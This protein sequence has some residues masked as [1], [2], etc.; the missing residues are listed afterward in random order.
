MPAAAPAFPPLPPRHRF[1]GERTAERILDA[2]EQLFAE[3]GYNGTTLRDVATRVGVRPPSLYNHFASKDAL[4]AAVLERG[5][6]PLM[7][8]LARS[9]AA[10]A[11]EPSD[12]GRLVSEVMAIL[13]RRPAIPR[14]V[15]H[16]TLAGGQRL[17]PIL[18]SWIVPA[19]ERAHELVAATPAAGRWSAEQIPLL[20][21]AMYQVVVGY[22]TFASFY[23][24]LGGEELLGDAALEA[25][26]RFLRELVGRLF[27]AGGN[28]DTLR[29]V[30]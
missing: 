18:R 22:F 3:R 10:P 21:L 17:T 6:G 5:I 30:R 9:A 29:G 2:A 8:L 24:D 4:Y 14:L 20:V 1:G 19:F 28:P 16:E 13:A 7:V 23:R 27:G 12:P 25:Q 15:Q 11:D 26:T